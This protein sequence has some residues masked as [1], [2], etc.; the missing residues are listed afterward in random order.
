LN[1][2]ELPLKCETPTASFEDPGPHQGY[3]YIKNCSC[4]WGA[5]KTNKSL[6]FLLLL[7]GGCRLVNIKNTCKIQFLGLGIWMPRVWGMGY[8]YVLMFV[9]S[10]LVVAN[11]IYMKSMR[12]VPSPRV[13]RPASC[14]LYPALLWHFCSGKLNINK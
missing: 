14:V 13:L 11:K 4:L 6:S 10:R 2:K 7:L 8:G 1:R 3:S 5:N 12:G 9:D